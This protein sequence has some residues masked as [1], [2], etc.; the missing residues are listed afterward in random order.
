MVMELIQIIYDVLFFGI[1]LLILVVVISFLLSKNS[2]RDRTNHNADGVEPLI[3]M[4][5]EIHNSNMEQQLQRK[6]QTNA[7]LHIFRIDQ[8]RPKEVKIVRKP[9]IIDRASQ[10]KIRDEE[11]PL[12][13]TNGDKKRYTIVNDDMKKTRSSVANFYL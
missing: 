6:N 7:N 10:E 5:G 8:H 2:N 12:K 13:K 9:T 4:T 3:R 1:S 11:S